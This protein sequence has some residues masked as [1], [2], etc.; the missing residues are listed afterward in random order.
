MEVFKKSVKLIKEHNERYERGEVPYKMA[1]NQFG[2]LTNEE[3][4]NLIN[5]QDDPDVVW[6]K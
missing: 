5:G 3:F 2:D 6:P 4:N 1:I